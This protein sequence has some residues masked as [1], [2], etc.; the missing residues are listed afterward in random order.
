MINFSTFDSGSGRPFQQ[1][2]DFQKNNKYING[3]DEYELDIC[4]HISLAES[5]V[6]DHKSYV[7]GNCTQLNFLNLRPGSVVAVK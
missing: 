6:F 1:Y 3:L 2:K 4:E 5:N 7:S